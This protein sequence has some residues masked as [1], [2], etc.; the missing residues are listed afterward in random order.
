M[1]KKTE[2]TTDEAKSKQDKAVLKQTD[3]YIAKIAETKQNRHVKEPTEPVFKELL[4]EYSYSY[5]KSI[6][7]TSIEILNFSKDVLQ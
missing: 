7:K 4:N 6:G 3:K 1:K 5:A 2:K